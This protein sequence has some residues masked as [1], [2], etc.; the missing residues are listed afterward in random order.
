MELYRTNGLTPPR[1]ENQCDPIDVAD[2]E[3]F[4]GHR[5]PMRWVDRI[6]QLNKNG[7]GSSESHIL[8]ESLALI[9]NSI[10]ASAHIEILGQT[11][12]Y[13]RAAECL[14]SRLRLDQAYLAA[15]D[16]FQ[17]ISKK[18]IGYGILI[19]HVKTLHEVPPF[20]IV[21]GQVYSNGQII[22]EARIKCYATFRSAEKP[23]SKR[24][25]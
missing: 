16:Y 19:S 15:I 2:L 24:E 3:E 11:Y 12:G 22:C 21:E 6:I 20:F 5:K 4:M 8:P 17:M 23:F 9:N 10:F 14:G 18:P 13:I 1:L 25:F 7:A